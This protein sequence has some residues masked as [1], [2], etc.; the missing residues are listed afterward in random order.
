MTTI[1]SVGSMSVLSP[2][3]HVAENSTGHT[4]PRGKGE[5]GVGARAKVMSYDTH[6]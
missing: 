1:N 6:F 4:Q 2:P 5:T 3:F